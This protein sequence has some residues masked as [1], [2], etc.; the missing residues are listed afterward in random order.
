MS[1]FNNWYENNPTSCDTKTSHIEGRIFVLRWVL[2]KMERRS[3][4]SRAECFRQNFIN[5][6][7]EDV[8]KELREMLEELP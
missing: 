6:F 1:K 8:E 7:V 2:E 4:E 3:H 5:V